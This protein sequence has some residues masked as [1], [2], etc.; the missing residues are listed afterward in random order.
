MEKPCFLSDLLEP[1][2]CHLDAPP[3]V[4][5]QNKLKSNANRQKKKTPFLTIS[6]TSQRAEM[7]EKIVEEKVVRRSVAI[8]WE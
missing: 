3:R 1:M 5:H 6:G 7:S 2:S 4:A 8:N